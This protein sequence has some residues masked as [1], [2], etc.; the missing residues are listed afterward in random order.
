MDDKGFKNDHLTFGDLVDHLRQNGFNIGIDSHLR[1]QKVL[2]KVSG[3]CSPA[4]LK[5]LLCPI[6][7]TNQKQ[8]EFFYSAFDSYFGLGQSLEVSSKGGTTLL[9]R[10]PSKV[11]KEPI[12]A[13]RWPY[14]LVGILL[15]A[16]T[17]AVLYYHKQQT[18][19]GTPQPIHAVV[20]VQTQTVVHN[21]PVPELIYAIRGIAMLGPL[22]FVGLYEFYLHKRR[23]LLLKN[24][25]SN[26]QPHI[27]PL[28]PKVALPALFDSAQFRDS[29]RVL[30]R[31][32]V[33][34]FSLLDIQATVHATT[35][36]LGYPQFR[37]KRASRVPEYLILIERT[38]Y[39]DHLAA[40]FDELTRAL[41]RDG[42]V[43]TQFYYDGDPRVCFQAIPKRSTTQIESEIGI[44]LGTVLSA[45]EDCRLLI[46]GT[47][48]GLFDPIFG[49]LPEWTNIFSKVNER[50]VITPIPTDEWIYRER[51]LSQHFFIV[52]ATLDGLQAL[53][54]YYER[55]D[56]ISPESWIPKE[57]TK[58]PLDLDS[59]SALLSLH[60]YLEDE[61]FQWLCACAVYPRLEWDLTIYVRFLPCMKPALINE[62]HLLRL[63]RLPWFRSGSMPQALRQQLISRLAPNVYRE[64][65]EAI[66]EL[67]QQLNEVSGDAPRPFN[68]AIPRAKR[69]FSEAS[70]KK[71]LGIRLKARVLRDYVFVHFLE[72]KPNTLLDFILPRTLS[73]LF[74]PSGN[75]ALRSKIGVRAL[76]TL[77]VAIAIWMTAPVIARAIKT[78]PAL[79]A[80]LDSSVASTPSPPIPSPRAGIPPGSA[81]TSSLA[82][83]LSPSA[84]RETAALSPSSQAT[85][86]SSPSTTTVTASAINSPTAEGTLGII[87]TSPFVPTPSPSAICPEVRVVC[88]IY[89][90]VQTKMSAATYSA[91]ATTSGG[92]VLQEARYV[93]SLAYD[94]SPANSTQG[95][96]ISGQGENKVELEW[97]IRPRTTPV[98]TAKVL[99]TGYN[100]ACLTEASCTVPVQERREPSQPSNGCECGECSG[101][102]CCPSPGYCLGCGSCG[103][104][105]CSGPP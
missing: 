88:S 60:A 52:P 51:T 53:T 47:G 31:R 25:R 46:M 79:T 30:R 32:Q 11:E 80:D 40:F 104:V 1:L 9:N 72:S 33:A 28:Q 19:I 23:T 34:E 64:V 15:T 26:Y 100:A 35:K 41:E 2:S 44:P 36:S 5:T 21:E 74:Y 39:S 62:I 16:I 102:T 50:A 13:Q 42:L 71:L 91:T 18:Q 73:R 57:A 83:Q 89:S 76:V 6:F 95:R 14:V 17:A 43:I 65:Q 20:R 38:T 49:T 67:L 29:T 54:E 22:L 63:M 69:I 77:L 27:L 4:D 56:A 48:E 12:L 24:L 105:C 98:L 82:P 78:E 66:I 92:K 59:P 58:T 103:F 10:Q 93:W 55:A 61:A 81:P 84:T 86:A 85:P 68:V 75:T 99:V 8:Q 7:A 45:H 101:I 97:T 96:I 90:Q 87:P 3:N 94:G 37:Y 70:L